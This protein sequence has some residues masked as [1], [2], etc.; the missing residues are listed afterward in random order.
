M[1]ADETQLKSSFSIKL[2]MC[3]QCDGMLLPP[4]RK[5]FNVGAIRATGKTW[6][7]LKNDDATRNGL[8]I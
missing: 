8:I 5:Y 3:N 2:Y 6:R 4:D 7:S 1:A